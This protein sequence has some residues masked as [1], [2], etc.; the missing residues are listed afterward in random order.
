VARELD[1]SRHA[2]DAFNVIQQQEK[3][4]QLKLQAQMAAYESEAKRLEMQRVAIQE[5]ERRKTLELET[6]HMKYRA[7]EQ[8]KLAR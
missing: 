7:Q 5:E 4:E 6:S 8:D 2:Q 3:T 1:Q